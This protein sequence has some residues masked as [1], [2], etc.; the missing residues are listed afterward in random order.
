MLSKVIETDA[1]ALAMRLYRGVGPK[2]IPDDWIKGH[3]AGFLVSDV[4]SWLG[5]TRSETQMFRDALPSDMANEPDD[6]IR[7]YARAEAQSGQPLIGATFSKS[8]KEVY[9]N[10]LYCFDSEAPATQ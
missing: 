1:I 8:G 7:L 5:D 4:R 9:L 3:I 10:Y 2:R 6:A